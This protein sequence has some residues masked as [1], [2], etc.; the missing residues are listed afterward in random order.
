MIKKKW[1]RDYNLAEMQINI[2]D[3][4]FKGEEPDD[5]IVDIKEVERVINQIF[6]DIKMTLTKIDGIKEPVIFLKEFGK[7]QNKYLNT[8]KPKKV[9][10]IKMKDFNTKKPNK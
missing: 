9:Q 4:L 5:C 2:K 10:Q 1:L 6:K 7:L 3:K 8:D